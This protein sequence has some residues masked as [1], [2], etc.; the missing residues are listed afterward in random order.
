MDAVPRLVS[1][2]HVPGDLRF[3]HKLHDRPKQR[4]KHR[5]RDEC[6]FVCE[7]ERGPGRLGNG[8]SCG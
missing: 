7:R 3:I 5:D 4:L 2:P 8:L 6:V 1:D